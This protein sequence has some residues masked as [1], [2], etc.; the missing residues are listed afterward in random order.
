[1]RERLMLALDVADEAEAMA[2][3][4]KVGAE[5]VWVKIGLRLFVSEGPSLVRRLLSHYRVFLDLKFH[6]IPNTVA[7]A[8]ESA[9]DLGVQMV[10]VHVAGGEDMMAAA[11]QAARAFPEMRLV[12]VTL[13]TSQGL[14]PHEAR[15]E[16]CR[17]ALAAK[18]AGCHG[19]VCSAHEAAAVKQVCG[20]GFLTVTPGIRMP[21]HDRDD[22]KRVADPAFAVRNGA[23][24]LV[25]GRPILRAADPCA[26]VHAVISEMKRAA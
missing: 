5:L 25:M 3:L 9:G 20:E 21:A 12:A 23:D 18:R 22:Q 16:V 13:L 15:E 11:A 1:M 4:N 17:A 26:V 24:F 8:V 19:V 10:N 6:D 14:D 7:Q 2:V